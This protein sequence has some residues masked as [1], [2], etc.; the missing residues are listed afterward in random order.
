M[1]MRHLSICYQAIVRLV[2]SRGS[3]IAEKA[4]CIHA[5]TPDKP[6]RN[7]DSQNKAYPYFYEP[8]TRPC[9]DGNADE[10]CSRDGS[11]KED[12]PQSHL[13]PECPPEN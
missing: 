10:K 8:E 12:E 9:S 7:S 5:A 1:V 6:D 2:D 11:A 4:K 3:Q 13:P